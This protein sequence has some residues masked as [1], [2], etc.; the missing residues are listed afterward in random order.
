MS[1]VLREVKGGKPIPCIRFRYPVIENGAPVRDAKGQPVR[2]S[3]MRDIPPGMTRTEAR[4]WEARLKATAKRYGDPDVACDADGFR[5]PPPPPKPPPPVTLRAIAVKMLDSL[6]WTQLKPATRADWG[7]YIRDNILPYFG[8]ESA[9]AWHAD[10][11]RWGELERLLLEE[12][13]FSEHQCRN[14]ILG[15][16]AILRFGWESRPQ[17]IPRMLTPKAPTV[18]P[19]EYSIPTA[20][21]IGSVIAHAGLASKYP[22][23]KRLAI[24][25]GAYSGA[26]KGEMRGAKKEHFDLDR[27]IGSGLWHIQA[28]LWHGET[29][30]P[31]SGKTRIV[32]LHADLHRAL[33]D[34]FQRSPCEYV[35][36][37]DG[38]PVSMTWIN[39]ALND[40]CDLAGVPRFRVHYLRHFAITMWVECGVNLVVVQEWAGHADIKTTRRYIHIAQKH[41]ELAMAQVPSI[42]IASPPL[43]NG[44]PPTMLLPDLDVAP[45]VPTEPSQTHLSLVPRAA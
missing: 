44:P 3:C 33:I 1:L 30:T 14:A 29:I 12:L 7:R 43:D 17:L 22:E 45:S 25:L 27:P 42:L 35:L 4:I 37:T 21:V 26:R 38:G 10:G 23:Q 15:V 20:A 24:M 19:I 41:K 11:D 39:S 16:R 36:S 31:K 8:D 40:A 5:I 2:K 13:D 6:Y 9:V 28:N 32:T 34:W 18:P